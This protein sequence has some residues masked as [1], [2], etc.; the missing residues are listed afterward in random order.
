MVPEV[1]TS[2]VFSPFSASCLTGLIHFSHPIT[3]QLVPLVLTCHQGL[4]PTSSLTYSF[5]V[6]VPSFQISKSNTK[7]TTFCSLSSPSL[8]QTW[9]SS[10]CPNWKLQRHLGALISLQHLSSYQ[11][12]CIALLHLS[13]TV[14]L[15][16]FLILFPYSNFYHKAGPLANQL[17]PAYAFLWSARRWIFPNTQ[18]FPPQGSSADLASWIKPILLSVPFKDFKDL[19]PSFISSPAFWTWPFVFS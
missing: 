15:F 10:S 9:F 1:W 13:W 11:V 17:S 7:S 8:R 16:T 5:C 6:D 14:S 4:T 18:H 2:A 12:Q 3:P 19:T